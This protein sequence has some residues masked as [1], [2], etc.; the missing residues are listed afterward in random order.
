MK[1]S[2][3]YF[4][5]IA[6]LFLN[7]HFKMNGQKK[8]ER[9]YR[10]KADQFPDIAIQ[11]IK[12]GDFNANKIKYYIESDSTRHSFE[13]KFKYKDRRYSIEFDQRGILEDIEIIVENDFLNKSL[14][15]AIN[16]RLDSMFKRYRVLKIQ[17]QYPNTEA[18]NPSELLARAKLLKTSV[19]HNY[20]ILIA[21]RKK[22]ES[23][24]DYELLFD[25]AGNVLKIRKSVPPAYGYILY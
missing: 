13:A 12:K 8:Y 4:I 6:L 15:E 1:L 14:E 3:N 10:I 11:Y 7:C 9:E 18:Y 23:Y 2:N 17:L 25:Q 22:N 5:L 24:N 16:S 20:E 21:A 19:V